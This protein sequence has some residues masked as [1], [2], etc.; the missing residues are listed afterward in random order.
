MEV[1][2]L[3]LEI[4]WPMGLPVSDLRTFILDKIKAYGDPLR[5]SISHSISSEK[6]ECFRK[7]IIEVAITND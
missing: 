5:W 2:S 4:E 1:K 7:M 3:E 6:S